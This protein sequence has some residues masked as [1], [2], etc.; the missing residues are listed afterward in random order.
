MWQLRHDLSAHDAVYVALA[1][2]LD[3]PLPTT[4]ER[5]SRAPGHDAVV[6]LAR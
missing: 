3:A 5:L 2:A 1:E 4:D 6:E